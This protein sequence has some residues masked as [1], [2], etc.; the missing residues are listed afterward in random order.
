M[1]LKMG[2]GHLCFVLLVN[3]VFGAIVCSDARAVGGRGGYDLHSPG[4]A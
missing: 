3:L 2:T 4:T 1:T